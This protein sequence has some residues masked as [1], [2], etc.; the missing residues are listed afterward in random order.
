MDQNYKNFKIVLS[1]E[2]KIK[3]LEEILL[4]LKK[5]IHVYEK[6]QEPNSSYNYKVF[7]GGIAIYVS[8][9]NILFNGEL[10]NIIININAILSNNFNK[11]Q[12]KTIVFETINFVNYLHDYYINFK[13][14]ESSCNLQ[15]ENGGDR[16]WD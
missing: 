6:S 2:E 12:L 16:K 5:I 14:E 15:E 11:Q 7:C 4:R 8:S 3:C 10:V 13:C 9:A 1:E